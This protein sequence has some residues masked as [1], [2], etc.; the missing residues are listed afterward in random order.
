MPAAFAILIGFQLL[1]EIVRHALRLPLPGPLI[2]MFLLAVALAARARGGAA[3]LVQV[4][5]GLITHM[6]LLFVPAGVGVIVEMDLL[7]ARF[8]PILAGL[9]VSTLLGLTVTAWVMHHVCRIAEAGPPDANLP[10]SRLREA[11]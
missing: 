8:L 11:L 9:V 3:P 10:A 7:R 5:N 1:G 6:G 2:G 4:S